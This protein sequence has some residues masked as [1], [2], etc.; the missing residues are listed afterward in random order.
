VRI[1]L[2][3]DFVSKVRILDS[4][5]HDDGG[6]GGHLGVRQRI[7]DAEERNV[8]GAHLVEFERGEGDVEKDVPQIR[9]GADE[10]TEFLLILVLGRGQRLD[11]QV[12]YAAI[13][14]SFVFLVEQFASLRK[15]GV[16]FADLLDFRFWRDVIL[17]LSSSSSSSSTSAVAVLRGRG[18][19]SAKPGEGGGGGG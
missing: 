11:E 10:K 3:E 13:D 4:E 16:F 8:L 9:V 6:V 17:V 15:N 5:Q 12:A 2:F 14:K 7:R 19:G 18:D 1:E